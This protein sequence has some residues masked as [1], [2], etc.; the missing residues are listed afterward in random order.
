MS[1][2]QDDAYTSAEAQVHP[3]ETVD[4]LERKVLGEQAEQRRLEDATDA[5]A[6]DQDVDEEELSR[7]SEA[8]TPQEPSG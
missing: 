7:G 4:A 6:F 2:S 5:P 8:D 1:S 3:A